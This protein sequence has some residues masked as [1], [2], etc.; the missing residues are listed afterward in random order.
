MFTAEQIKLIQ[1][2]F[3]RELQAVSADAFRRAR[4]SER[5][6]RDLDAT[7]WDQEPFVTHRQL[8]SM[9]H[10]LARDLQSRPYWI[11][12]PYRQVLVNTK[13]PDNADWSAQ[14]LARQKA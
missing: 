11:E 5:E 10:W 2:M 6:R 14:R 9:S 7:N 3:E 8:E 4:R 13:H 12:D 1:E